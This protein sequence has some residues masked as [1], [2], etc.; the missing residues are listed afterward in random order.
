MTDIQIDLSNGDI[1]LVEGDII[2]VDGPEAVAQNLR[3][4]FQFFRSEWFLDTRLGVP[5]FTDILVKNPDPRRLDFI[6]RQVVAKTTGIAEI[7]SLTTV[8]DPARRELLIDFVAI[9]NTRA[10][11]RSAD[12][13]PFIIDLEGLR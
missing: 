7:M 10:V 13:G 1:A 6:F 9:L 12:Y 11:F 2:L 8:I 3:V 5:Y 4:R